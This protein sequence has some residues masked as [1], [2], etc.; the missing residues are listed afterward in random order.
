MVEPKKLTTSNL[1]YSQISILWS[2]KKGKY[3]MKSHYIGATLQEMFPFFHHSWVPVEGTADICSCCETQN[4]VRTT[5]QGSWDRW[6]R[7]L[8]RDVAAKLGM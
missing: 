6:G 2:I 1:G 4:C 3:W 7:R 5:G 8:G